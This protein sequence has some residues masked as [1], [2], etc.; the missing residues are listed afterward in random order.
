VAYVEGTAWVRRLRPSTADRR[1]VCLPHV[2]GAAS[3]FAPLAAALS[4]TADVLALQYPGRQDRRGEP[5]VDSI[6][7]LTA[8][9]LPELRPWLD[10]PFVLLGHSMGAVVAF[11]LARALEAEAGPADGAPADGAPSGGPGA[12]AGVEGAAPLALVVSGRRGPTTWRDEQL[13]RAG[14]ER[15]LQELTRLAGT[16]AALL[17][18]EDVRQ[19]VLPALRADYTAIETYR[20][21]PGPPLR[22]PVWALVGEED[23]LTTKDEA[24]AWEVHT[25]GPFEL[26]TFPGG[27]FY[28]ADLHPDLLALLTRI[29]ATPT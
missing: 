14:D 3:Y 2:G 13:H 24:A 26:R 29:L 7:S 9:I 5:C 16:P 10:R 17:E 18:D 6:E 12:A 1:L 8:A 20:W 21:Q 11:E 22:C 28:L 15:M 23:P 27:H 25:R 4:G 19:M